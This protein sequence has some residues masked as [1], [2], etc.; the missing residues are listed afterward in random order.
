MGNAIRPGATFSS[1]APPN[2]G[3][4]RERTLVDSR[5]LGAFALLIAA[6]SRRRSATRRGGRRAADRPGRPARPRRRRDRGEGRRGRRPQL[7]H[8]DRRR[9]RPRA[10]VRACGLGREVAKL[11]TG[12]GIVHGRIVAR[13]PCDELALVETQPRIP[14]LVSLADKAGARPARARWS[15]PTAAASRAARAAS[16]RCPRRSRR[17]AK[18]DAPLVPEAAGG[19]VLD[20][21]GRLVGIGSHDGTTIPWSAI[22]LSLDGLV[23]G[24]RRVFAG[25]QG[26]YD[27]AAR[28][29]RAP[30][31]RTPRSSPRTCAW[32]LRSPRRAFR[33]PRRS[34]QDEPDPPA[35]RGA[36]RGHEGSGRGRRRRRPRH[37]GAARHDLAVVD[38][39]DHRRF[40]QAPA[41][42]DSPFSWP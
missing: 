27:C 6:C 28:L 38:A 24:V 12:L 37:E 19:P 9:A 40:D 33:D 16:S 11:S 22:K 35:V 32:S 1:A 26:Q 14:G 2:V 13:A 21:Q 17:P 15:P 18:L 7:R 34:M 31:P 23:P 39:A 30:G 25:W 3:S 20:A 36:Q 4:R 8:R 29:N 5:R 10:H 42:I 41:R